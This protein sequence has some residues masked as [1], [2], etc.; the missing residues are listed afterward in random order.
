MRKKIIILGGF[1]ILTIVLIIFYLFLQSH[2]AENNTLPSPFISVTPAIPSVVAS[3][4]KT[5]SKPRTQESEE[6][7]QAL[8]AH[9]P[10]STDNFT[11]EYLAASD[12]FIITIEQDPYETNKTAAEEWLRS[13]GI[14]DLQSLTIYWNKP[15]YVQ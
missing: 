10:Y 15:R 2:T 14:T 12:S 13:Q 11:V 4:T 1:S 9:L 7:K 3:P 5:P 6:Q 8:I